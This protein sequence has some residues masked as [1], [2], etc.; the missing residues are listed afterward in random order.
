MIDLYLFNTIVNTIWY[1]FTILFVLYRFTSFFSYIYN[2]VRFCGKLF[3]GVNYVYNEIKMYI[4]RRS[5]YINLNSAD[6]EAQTEIL[7]PDQNIRHKTIFETFKET[8]AKK[9]NYYYYMIF[10][11][12]SEP[13]STNTIIPLVETTTTSH[14]NLHSYTR[15]SEQDLF[16]KHINEL[17]A[18]N[19]SI[20]F[21]NY[22]TS[23]DKGDHK[24]DDKDYN[25]GYDKSD[26]KSD[27]NMF[28]TVDLNENNDSFLNSNYFKNFYEPIVN[29]PY[30][31][32]DSNILF[33]SNF[34]NTKLN[35]QKNNVKV[36]TY[37]INN[38]S[39]SFRTNNLSQSFRTSNL[40][41]NLNTIREEQ[42]QNS[43][44]V[45]RINSEWD[46][47]FPSE[48]QQK[49]QHDENDNDSDSD[50]DNTYKNAILKNPY[51]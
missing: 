15:N 48:Y 45:F 14:N 9:Y 50:I 18:N 31:V 19:S 20:E 22:I 25:K 23:N 33:D 27:D 37:P 11:K 49:Y 3:V 47:K 35:N 8:V 6:I 13:T 51:I 42:E 46:E 24:S 36:E 39:Q 1:I 32:E 40:S 2:F 10:G 34:M 16:D 41:Q 4:R 38:F 28:K 30:N 7:L 44:I 5:G 12:Q 43:K 21:D 26:Y 17:S 29:K